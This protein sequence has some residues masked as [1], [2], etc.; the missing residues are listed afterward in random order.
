MN[1]STTN[2]EYTEY[3]KSPD[4]IW[5]KR[6]LDVQRPYRWNLRRLEPGFF[7]DIG[8]G[9]GR[10]LINLKGNGIGID[11]NSASI[12]IA[13]KQGLN[14]FTSDDFNKS[15]FFIEKSFDSIL[16]SHVAEHMAE[17]DVVKLLKT[18]LPLLKSKGKVIIITPQEKGYKSDSTHNQFMNF[19]TLQRII[20]KLNLNYIKKYSFPFPRII[21]RYFKYNEFVFIAEK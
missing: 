8:C 6:L 4:L 5:W 11:H 17:S 13:R 12:E 7:L 15:E 3:L 9:V 21:G 14:C 2:T 10:N 20:D 16:L 1:K 18:Y 19:E